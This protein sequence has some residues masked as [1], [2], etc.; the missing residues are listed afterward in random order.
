M[1][2]YETENGMERNFWYGIWQMPEWNGMEDFKNEMEDNLPYFHPN[3]RLDF[4]YCIYRKIHTD[5]ARE[6]AH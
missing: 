6:Y 1:V 4:V 2:W 3:F 5:I